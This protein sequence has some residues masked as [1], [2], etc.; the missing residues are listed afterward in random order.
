MEK[1][2]QLYRGIA[3]NIL[4]APEAE[5]TDDTELTGYDSVAWLHVIIMLD[6]IFGVAADPDRVR[7]CKTAGDVLRLAS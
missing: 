6:E 1:R 4:E 3:E 5:V 7:A 2:D